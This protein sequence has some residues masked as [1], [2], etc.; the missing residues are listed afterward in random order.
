MV[1]CLRLT[2]F[3]QERR[4]YL[5]HLANGMEGPLNYVRTYEARYNE[6]KGMIAR[7]TFHSELIFS[8]KI[9]R[10]TLALTYRF[11]SYGAPLTA[12]RRHS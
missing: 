11:F 1:A 9:F 5:D 10:L 7:V 3:E 8:S 4:F 12:Q 6:E 2:T